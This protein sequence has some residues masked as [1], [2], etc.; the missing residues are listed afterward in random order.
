MAGGLYGGLKFS[1][2]GSSSAAPTETPAI[3]SQPM[4]AETLK[5]GSSTEQPIV[6][7]EAPKANDKTAQKTA[8]KHIYLAFLLYI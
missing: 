6:V 2:A 3:T 8:G 5:T 7:D 4:I 1:G